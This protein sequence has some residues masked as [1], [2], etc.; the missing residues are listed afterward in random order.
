MTAECFGTLGSNR[1]LNVEIATLG[2]GLD[3]ILVSI[4]R[5]DGVDSAHGDVSWFFGALDV[6]ETSFGSTKSSKRW[7]LIE[8]IEVRAIRK[9]S[10]SFILIW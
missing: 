3:G 7:S 5:L 8:T 6:W 10:I 9:V 2:Y 1:V 4:Q